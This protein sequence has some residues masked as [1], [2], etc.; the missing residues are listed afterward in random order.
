MKKRDLLISVYYC[1]CA[2]DYIFELLRKFSYTIYGIYIF[3]IYVI[4]KNTL[5]DVHQCYCSLML[6]F[7]SLQLF[8]NSNFKNGVRKIKN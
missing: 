6:I 4:S 1:F 3:D 5:Y 7:L 8:T 2:T